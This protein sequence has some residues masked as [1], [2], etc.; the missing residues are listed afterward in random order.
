M[1]ERIVFMQTED[2][3]V[4]FEKEDGSTIT[5]PIFL[6][7]E[8]YKEGDIIKVILHADYIEF[9]ELDLDEMERRKVILQAKKMSLKE[10][11]KRNTSKA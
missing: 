8:P 11:I 1:E 3:M 4:T 7:P 10:R 6:I 5:Y 9:L 2:M